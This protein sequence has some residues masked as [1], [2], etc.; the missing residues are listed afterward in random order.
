[1][2]CHLEEVYKDGTRKRCE[3]SPNGHPNHVYPSRGWAR[4]SAEQWKDSWEGQLATGKVKDDAAP[5]SI[6]LVI[7][8]DGRIAKSL[9]INRKS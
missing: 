5:V 3:T 9:P 6:D 4:S 8:S 1:M 7:E 2:D